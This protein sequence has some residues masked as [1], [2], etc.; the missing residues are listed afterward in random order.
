MRTTG[1]GAAG[2]GRG[3]FTSELFWLADRQ[4]RPVFPLQLLCAIRFCKMNARHPLPSASQARRRPGPQQL[5][6]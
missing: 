6:E 1:P 2:R 5:I 3:R 4:P